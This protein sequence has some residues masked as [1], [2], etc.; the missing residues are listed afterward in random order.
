MAGFFG[1]VPMRGDFVR[2][3]L[4]ESFIRPWDRW[5][6]AAIAGSREI[7]GDDWLAAYLTC[8]VWRFALSA[9]MA[10]ELAAAGVFMPSVDSVGRYFPFTLA[11]VLQEGVTPVEIRAQ[12]QWFDD[13]ETLALTV[14]ADDAS[15]DEL[16]PKVEQLGGPELAAALPP[17]D[18][19][20]RFADDGDGP[21]LRQVE[22]SAPPHG[23]LWTSGSQRVQPSLLL[24]WQLPSPRCFTALLDGAWAAHGW[25]DAAP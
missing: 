17:D 15:F 11:C 14:L 6:Q 9:D 21:L 20:M 4:P 19:G 16:V 1:K 13:A 25:T 12:G 22:R 18:E 3:S 8:P 5:L 24:I 10:G 2:R 7:L 23:L